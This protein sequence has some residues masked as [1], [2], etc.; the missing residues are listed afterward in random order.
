[1]ERLSKA[2]EI[3]ES[4]QTSFESS[5][6]DTRNVES[7]IRKSHLILMESPRKTYGISKNKGRRT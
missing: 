4:I 5:L 7:S 6:V 2:Y 1:M 3:C